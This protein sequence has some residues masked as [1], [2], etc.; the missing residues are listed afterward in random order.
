MGKFVRSQSGVLS[1]SMKVSYL[2]LPEAQ[3]SK[4]KVVIPHGAFNDTPGREGES[5]ILEHTVY[6]G[7]QSR[8][9]QEISQLISKIGGR[10]EASTRVDETS[11]SLTASNRKQENF[12]IAADLMR[13]LL[14]EPLFPEA[15]LENE[16]QVIINE[17]ARRIDNLQEGPM[18]VLSR[19]IHANPDD[20]VDIIGSEKTIR[21]T[22]AE[23]LRSMMRCS[24][25]A[26][27]IHVYACSH[28]LF[29][30][31]MHVFE[32][33]LSAVPNLGLSDSPEH[34]PALQPVD[35]RVARHD[36][37]QNYTLFFFQAP[38]AKDPKTNKIF[39]EANQYLSETLVDVLRAQYGCFYAAEFM[40]WSSNSQDTIYEFNTD[41]TPEDSIKVCEGMI[42]FM[43]ELEEHLPDDVIRERL[44]NELYGLSDFRQLDSSWVDA[45]AYYRKNFD[46]EFDTAEVVRVYSQIEPAEVRAAVRKIMSGLIGMHVQ[47]PEPHKPPSL[48]YMREH[49]KGRDSAVSLKRGFQGPAQQPG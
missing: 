13:E 31:A 30:E 33:T 16:I 5:H 8:S 3:S 39:A 43:K 26:S 23:S 42:R 11:F 40:K 36:L 35:H 18:D 37:L 22:S 34:I 1:N 12:S 24:Y 9:E 49:L 19:M 4:I 10:K 45:V 25:D 46:K 28:L 20:Y 2:H 6:L 44:E 17:R 29:D 27:Q 38:T 7:T 47:G 48:E 41:S 15:I 21:A 32:Q 14:T